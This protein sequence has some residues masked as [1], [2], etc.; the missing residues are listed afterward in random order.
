MSSYFH[1]TNDEFQNMLQTPTAVDKLDLSFPKTTMKNNATG[2]KINSSFPLPTSDVAASVAEENDGDYENEVLVEVVPKDKRCRDKI[3]AELALL[4]DRLNL[5]DTVNG[6]LIHCK[7]L[8][9]RFIIRILGC[10]LIKIQYHRYCK[11]VSCFH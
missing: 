5:P 8:F 9:V 11:P 10:G 7:N 6:L 4:K 2:N 1:A 3:S